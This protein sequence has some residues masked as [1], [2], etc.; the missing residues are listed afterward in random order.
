MQ[1]A[2]RRQQH[3]KWLSQVS[4]AERIYVNY[5]PSDKKLKGVSKVEPTNR[6]LGCKPGLPDSSQ[7]TYIN[8]KPVV[9]QLTIIF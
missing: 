4:F 8:F 1:P 6:K 7:V 3:S 5:N 2:S 9:Q